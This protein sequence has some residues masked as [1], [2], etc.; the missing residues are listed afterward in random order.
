MLQVSAVI[1]R[2][3]AL[4]AFAS[5]LSVTRATITT[6]TAADHQEEL[7]EEDEGKPTLA[8]QPRPVHAKVPNVRIADDQTTGDSLVAE[9]EGDE[10]K[11]VVNR[12]VV[13]ESDNIVTAMQESKEK[14]PDPFANS[15]Q[16]VGKLVC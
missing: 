1:M 11:G 14:A 10:S 7:K 12:A 6:E 8:E 15:M 2:L 3:L 5:M 9:K 13:E 16:M 4:V